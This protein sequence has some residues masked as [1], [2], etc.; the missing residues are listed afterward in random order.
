MCYCKKKLKN[1]VL[2]EHLT[3]FDKIYIKAPCGTCPSCRKVKSNDWVVRSYF[4]FL[5]NHSQAFFLSLDFDNEHLPTYKGTPCFDS[6][7]MKHFL[8][9]LR[10][11]LGKFRYLYATDYGGL[12]KRPHYHLILLPVRPYNIADV[13]K[14][15]SSSW[16][17]GS[18]SNIEQVQSVNN[19]K[20]KAIKYVAGYTTKDISFQL[21]DDNRDMPS[22]FR[23]RVQASKGF[24]LRAL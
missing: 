17:C 14:A 23:P 24:G 4:E 9:R 21:S 18:H 3:G 19:D 20:I 13:V 7:I 5:G 16:I 1:R 11:Y 6:E 22:R 15:V 8:M 2:P 10:Y 12:L